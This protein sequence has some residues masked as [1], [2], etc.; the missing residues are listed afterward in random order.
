MRKAASIVRKYAGGAELYNDKIKGGRSIKVWG[1]V[2]A[3]HYAEAIKE[4][5]AE[6]YT[7]KVKVYNA[8]HALYPVIG[9]V[10]IARLHCL[11]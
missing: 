11:A 10:K 8:Q 7:V 5:E 3:E 4:L 1:F 2:T 6:G 9:K